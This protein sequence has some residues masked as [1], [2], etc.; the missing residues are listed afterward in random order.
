[1]HGFQLWANLPAAPQDDAAALS[2]IEAADI[3]VV[4]DDDGTQV[5]LSAEHSG[6]RQVP[7]TALPPIP[8][9]S[10]C[11]VPPGLRKTLPSNDAPRVRLRI[12]GL[13][14]N[15]ATRRDLSKCRPS[16]SV[17]RTRTSAAAENRSLVLFD[18]GDEVMVQA[19]RRR[20]PLS[21]RLGEASARAGG[22]YGPIADEYAGAT[23]PGLRGAGK[24]TFSESGQKK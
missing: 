21:T 19:R 11:P 10:M 17:G 20:H 5:R 23:P 2:R 13:G 6:E 18:R 3:P 16:R 4:T 22:L 12:R 7:S 14:G 24:G 1:M 8:S 15:S 9:I